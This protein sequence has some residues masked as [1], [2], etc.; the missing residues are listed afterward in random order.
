M[1]E[2]WLL[3]SE[4]AIRVAA[5]NP[6]GRMP[7]TIPRLNTLEGLPDPKEVLFSLLRTAS[8]LHG[9]RLRT[10]RV[11]GLVSRIVE[12]LDDFSVLR[13]LPAFVA[14]EEQLSAALADLTA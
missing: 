14:F 10:L 12:L 8:D 11:H 4:R 2:A 1:T 9:R 13:A 7:L 6:H 5:G 3:I